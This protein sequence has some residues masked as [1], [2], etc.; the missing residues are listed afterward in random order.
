MKKFT[1]KE[2]NS[3]YKSFNK[4][5]FIYP[6]PLWFL[7]RYT[8]KED[9][10]TAGLI[11][12]SLAYGNIKIIMKSVETILN[13]LGDEPSKTLD[14]KSDSWLKNHTNDFVHRFAKSENITGLLI[15]IREIRK[16]YKSLENCFLSGYSKNHENILNAACNFSSI[17]HEMAYPYD[18][19]HLMPLAEKKS[20]CKRLN[21]YL[22]WMVRNDDV[23]PGWWN[24]DK[25]KLI[26]PLDTHMHKIG[27]EYGLTEK[28]SGSMK[29]AIEITK[30]FMEFSPDDPVKYDFALTRQGIRKTSGLFD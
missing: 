13:L 22:R 2:L 27:I 4:K 3:V 20:A 25:S 26:I 14:L 7:Y 10:E 29:T 6:D 24:I 9:I 11:A 16:K 17:I 18:P 1:K 12:S 23:D 21:L 8:K 19:G 15:S 30:G 5:E 28:K